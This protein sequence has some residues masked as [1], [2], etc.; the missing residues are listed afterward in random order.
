MDETQIRDTDAGQAETEHEHEHSLEGL[1]PRFFAHAQMPCNLGKP[2]RWDG[3]A[4]GVGVCGD[5][6]EFFIGVNGRALK[7]VRHLPN[8][9]VYTVACGS[10][11][12][13]L[14]EGR[15]LEE[16]LKIQPQDVA[17][18][19]GGL[20]ADHM[21]CANLAVNTLGEALDDYYRK[22][23]GRPTQKIDSGKPP[24]SKG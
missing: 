13:K 6:I 22:V 20:P 1:D 4:L 23:W 19:L 11:V 16:V 14:A 2:D 21:H 10:A 8:G 5:S 15:T 3:R 17:N 18:E 9:C 7:Q 24:A 12:S